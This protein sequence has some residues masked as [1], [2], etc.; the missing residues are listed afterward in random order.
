MNF[1]LSQSEEPTIE[2]NFKD[3]KQRQVNQKFK[4]KQKDEL[5]DLRMP[6]FNENTTKLEG[7]VKIKLMN[8]KKLDH[9][10]IKI[11]MVGQIICFNQAIQSSN[12]MSNGLDFE[13]TGTLLESNDYDFNFDYFQK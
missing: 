11:E 3:Q 2:I 1:F 9:L 6:I 8:N 7:S 10:G 5:Q 13:N 4:D 12:F